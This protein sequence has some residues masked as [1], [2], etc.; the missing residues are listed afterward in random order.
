MTFERLVELVYLM[1]PAYAA[2]MA[3]PFVKFWPGWN[4]PIARA[5]LGDHKTVVGFAL[6]VLVGV[7]AA[8]LQALIDWNRSL[9]PASDWLAIG[10]AQG[11]GAMGGDSTKSYFKRRL[12]VPPGAPWIPADQLDFVVG[13]LAL[14][15]PLLRLP[16]SDV[17][18]ILVVTFLGD[19]VVNHL[20]FQLGIRSTKW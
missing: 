6:G 19:I 9:L 7:L 11:L 1:L 17:A 2:N 10:L 8:W 16:W 20:S 18:L 3:P 15:L 4:R 14:M 12:G 5:R 13:A